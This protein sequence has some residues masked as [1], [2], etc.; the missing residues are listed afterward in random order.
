MP[1]TVLALSGHASLCVF[2]MDLVLC[3]VRETDADGGQR[4]CVVGLHDVAQEPHPELL[5]QGWGEGAQD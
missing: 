1:P 3:Q 2:A 4:L 5:G